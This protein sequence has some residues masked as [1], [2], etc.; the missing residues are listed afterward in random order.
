MVACAAVL[1]SCNNVLDEEGIA[2]CDDRAPVRLTISFGESAPMSRDVTPD[3][4]GSVPGLDFTTDLQKAMA[5]N[6]VY[7]LVF[8]AT[9]NNNNTLKYQV[10][11]LSLGDPTDNTYHTRT[12]QGTMLKTATGETVK[13]VVLANLHQNN[14]TV[15]LKDNT[16][17]ALNSQANV[18][19]YIDDMIGED[20][21]A[22]YQ[23]LIYNYNVTNDGTTGVW[24]INERR[25]PMWGITDAT[26]VP[27]ATGVTLDCYLYRAVA[28]V[29]I[30]V[31]MKDG[32]Q[33]S[34]NTV[35]TDDFKITKITV[36]N[37][38]SKGYCVSLNTPDAS[39]NVQYTAPFVPNYNTAQNVVYS[40]F[41]EAQATKAFSDMIYLPE[42]INSGNNITPVTIVVEY[43]YNGQSYTEANNNAGI[44]EFKDEKGAFDVIRN[45]SYIFNITSVGSE[46][47]LTCI[48]K[49]WEK[50]TEEW[51]FTDN[52]SESE[53][54]SWGSQGLNINS[55]TGEVIIPNTNE[56][57]CTFGLLT[58]TGG[59]WQASLIPVGGVT[60]AFEFVGAHSGTIGESGTG[61]IKLAI[62]AKYA[63]VINENNA[64]KLRIVVRTKDG[65]TLIANLTGS[66]KFSEYILVQNVNS[67]N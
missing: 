29:Q 25:I 28:K 64:A 6:D 33:G 51:D 4:D 24:D 46:F 31:N 9:N 63:T 67:S 16:S 39:E 27:A 48:V 47:S 15:K 38:N 36:K 17:L 41:T 61:T 21:T 23:K 44:I 34:D 20:Q 50:E 55:N 7:L 45:H 11:N 1:T 30:W 65:R 8:D 26:A 10:K 43:T 52:I 22:I 54:L 2:E 12:L 42:Q 13:L 19:K 3:N 60:D 57:N 53:N 56:Y 35:T 58:P 49:E 5:S 37:A 66:D 32:I 18:Q 40:T 59:T 14:I 62:K